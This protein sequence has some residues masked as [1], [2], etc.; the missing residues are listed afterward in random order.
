MADLEQWVNLD[1]D[2]KWVEDEITSVERVGKLNFE[3]TTNKAKFVSFRIRI[4]NASADNARYSVAE[5]GRNINFTIQH[6]RGSETNLGR[7]RIRVQR[8]IQVPAAGGNRYRIRLRYKGKGDADYRQ[9]QSSKF[10]VTRRKLLYYVVT[11]DS[12]TLPAAEAMADPTPLLTTLETDYWD[13]AKNYYIKLKK[14]A[15]VQMPLTKN[16]MLDEFD[17]TGADIGN[18][19][20]ATSTALS[21][22]IKTALAPHRPTLQARKPFCFVSVWCNYLASRGKKVIDQVVQDAAGNNVTMTIPSWFNG[23]WGTTPAATTLEVDVGD[24]LW[25]GLDDADDAAQ[26][27]LESVQLDFIDSSTNAATRIAIPN[28]RV[29]ISG[30][31]DKAFGAYHKIKIDLTPADMQGIR[32]RLFNQIRGTFRLQVKVRTAAGWTNGFAM[33]SK[34]VIVVADKVVW[35]QR[36]AAGKAQTLNH[37]FGH[38]VGMTAQ[39]G[40][41]AFGGGATPND[42]DAPATLYGNIHTGPTDNSHGHQGNHCQD[43]VT[44]TN[45][46]FNAV[47]NKWEGSWS[48]NAGAAQANCVMFGSNGFWTAA[49]ALVN[50][51]SRYC[52][53]CEPIVRKLDLGASMPGFAS[54]VTD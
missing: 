30:T 53:T 27:W 13:P 26:M 43:G 32:R 42:P 50:R 37:E 8:D 40:Q 12:S 4:D 51:N 41:V 3:I 15:A 24:Y 31:P 5:R 33:G 19:W 39:G 46:A 21:A 18:A 9:I 14:K 36:P 23:V 45:S 47:T 25:H 54:C 22:A 35:E 6:G 52:S 17:E 34:N 20:A 7:N 16:L 38:K 10:V 49:G 29:Q 2:A 28:N 44:W 1:K 11:M 48:L